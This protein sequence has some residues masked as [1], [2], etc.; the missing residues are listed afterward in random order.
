MVHV[1]K[2]NIK[3]YLYK[4]IND[5]NAMPV[6]STLLFF[7]SIYYFLLSLVDES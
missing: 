2:R 5:I 7:N 4:V 6:L 3:F 1:S